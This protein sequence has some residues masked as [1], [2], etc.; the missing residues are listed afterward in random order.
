LK[1]V[2]ENKKKSKLINPWISHTEYKIQ[3][4]ISY[5]HFKDKSVLDYNIS[6]CVALCKGTALIFEV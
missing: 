5:Y 1:S 4:K 2:L 6:I 3:I